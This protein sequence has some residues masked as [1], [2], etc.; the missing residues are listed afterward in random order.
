[1]Q[2]NMNLSYLKQIRQISAIIPAHY[3]LLGLCLIFQ[4]GSY[5][6]SNR[7]PTP[8]ERVVINKVV[9]TVSQVIDRFSDKNWVKTRGGG[10]DQQNYSVQEHPDVAMGVAPFDDW[11]F[12]VVENSPL[13]NST[14]KPSMDKLANIPADLTDKKTMDEYLKLGNDLK[15]LQHIY[16]EVHVNEKNLPIKPAQGSAI[17][18][19]V[20]G[21]YFSYKQSLNN[22]VGTN[23]NPENSYVFAF[24]NWGNA[25]YD[26]NLE[27]Y[28]FH[29]GHPPGTA[30]IENLVIIVSGNNEAIQRMIKSEKFMMIN[31]GLTK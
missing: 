2:P 6:Q 12:D 4:V 15:N 9:N 22:T 7:D 28:Q 26:A 10:M 30:F 3:L 21:C 1:M 16:V 29:F 24:G 23:L 5:S 18:L 20:P 31:E 14:I 13:W 8:A 17:D 19:K 11:Q 27:V 25:K